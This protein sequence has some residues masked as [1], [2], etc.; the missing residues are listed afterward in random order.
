MT[1]NNP[2]CFLAA[3][4]V[5]RHPDRDEAVC[6]GHALPALGLDRPDRNVGA[7]YA[8]GLINQDDL[9]RLANR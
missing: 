6:V 4:A 9:H 1:C 8:E 3:V 7:S 5:I 2:T